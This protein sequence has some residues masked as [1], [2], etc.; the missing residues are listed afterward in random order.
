MLPSDGLE[1]IKQCKKEEQKF[2][3]KKKRSPLLTFFPQ[4]ILKLV[5]LVLSLLSIELI[6]QSKTL[7][8]Y[9][10][11]DEGMKERK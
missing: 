1:S 3:N 8:I 6:M 7:F 2:R 11:M 5:L 9:G 10:I 4:I